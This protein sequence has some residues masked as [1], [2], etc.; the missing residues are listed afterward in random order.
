METQVRRYIVSARNDPLLRKPVD[1]LEV[2]L[3]EHD[4]GDPVSAFRRPSAPEALRIAAACRSPRSTRSPRA[5]RRRPAELAV[6]LAPYPAVN[7]DGNT[8]YPKSHGIV[9]GI[10]GR[11]SG[12]RTYTPPLTRRLHTCAGGG[13]SRKRRMRPVSSSWAIPAPLTSSFSNR[14]IVAMPPCFLWNSESLDRSHSR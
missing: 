11:I 2:Q 8:S 13:F 3:T 6:R 5:A 9:S 4:G 10:R 7:N 12:E 14:A 1:P